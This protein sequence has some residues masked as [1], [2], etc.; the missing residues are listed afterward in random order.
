MV[1][2]TGL[3]STRHFRSAD[4][5]FLCKESPT[6]PCAAALPAS[7]HLHL[8]MH[9]SISPQLQLLTSTCIL[10]NGPALSYPR[11]LAAA[12]RQQYPTTGS[13]TSRRAWP[14]AS[15]LFFWASG[16]SLRPQPFPILRSHHVAARIGSLAV[17]SWKHTTIFSMQRL[18][19]RAALTSRT[20]HQ[21]L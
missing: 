3:E 7:S 13:S 17:L 14:H 11:Q 19:T 1:V 9:S 6:F 16:R 21:V 2:V 18:L 12:S 5:F 20:C 15:C 10:S 8:H 4:V